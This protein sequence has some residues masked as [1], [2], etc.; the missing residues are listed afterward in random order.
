MILAVKLHVFAPNISGT[1]HII[2]SLVQG[3]DCHLKRKPLSIYRL[4][5]FMFRFWYRFVFPNMS[6][7]VMGLGASVFDHEVKS[8]LNA[9]MGLVFEDICKQWL[10]E[11]AKNEALPF[12]IG[13][14]GRWWG[15]NNKTRSQEEI[16]LMARRKTEMLFA[17]CKW[18]NAE[19]GMSVFRNLR[20]KGEMF[21]HEN[22]YFYLF[23]KSLFTEE[24]LCEEREHK[25]LRLLTL[26]E[27]V[28]AKG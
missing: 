23:A 18:T 6:A 13:N 16:D 25:S 3:L 26:E 1:L 5:D 8:D 10:F 11:Q 17:E 7:I 22:A 21:S 12:F 19:V 20:R 24:L 28:N 14:L 4:D 27:M 2:A 9:Y 15:T